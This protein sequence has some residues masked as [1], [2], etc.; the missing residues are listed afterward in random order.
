[1]TRA[2]FV[3]YRYSEM[4]FNQ[5][6]QSGKPLAAIVCIGTLLHW[7]SDITW[8][9]IFWHFFLAGVFTLAYMNSR[10]GVV[11]LLHSFNNTMAVLLS[12]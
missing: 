8:F 4:S 2:R 7:H 3:A 10:L 12:R 1:M 6:L 11:V 9:Y 5:R